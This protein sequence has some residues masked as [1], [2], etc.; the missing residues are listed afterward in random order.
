MSINAHPLAHKHAWGFLFFWVT[1][2]ALGVFQ[3]VL[4]HTRNNF[5]C[6]ICCWRGAINAIKKQLHLWH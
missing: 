5:V 1:F 3:V 4:A 2:K 6:G